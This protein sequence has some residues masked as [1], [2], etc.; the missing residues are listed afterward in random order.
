MTSALALTKSTYTL[1]PRSFRCRV[2]M[3][4][5]ATHAL[6]CFFPTPCPRANISADFGTTHA[7]RTPQASPRSRRIDRL[8]SWRKGT[9]P[10]AP[11]V[12]GAGVGTGGAGVG[13]LD[14]VPEAGNATAAGPSGGASG[15]R[16]GRRR[17]KKK[18]TSHPTYVEQVL[19]AQSVQVFYFADEC[20][21]EGTAA[22]LSVPPQARWRCARLLFW[23]GAVLGV[24]LAAVR[25][26]CG[27]ASVC[28]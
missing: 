10:V 3:P 18:K 13:S 19:F 6:I 24:W 22:D 25:G 27:A 20:G 26:Y 11:A 8:A 15:R 17:K 7:P 5:A 9:T 23:C 14:G 1:S 28:L 4:W 2:V 16:P 21:L 12:A